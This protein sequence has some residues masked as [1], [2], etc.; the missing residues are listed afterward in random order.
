M[1]LVFLEEY[2]NYNLLIFG[3]GEERPLLEKMINKKE[4]K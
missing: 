4:I 1:N 2:S 3:E